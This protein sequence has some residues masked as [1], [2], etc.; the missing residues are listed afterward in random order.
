MAKVLLVEDDA[1]LRELIA[2]QIEDMGH[3][4]VVASDGKE[5]LQ[6]AAAERPQI[7]LSDIG[8]PNMNGYEFRQQLTDRY[9]HMKKLPFVFVSAYADEVDIADG[10]IAGADRYITKPIDFDLLRNWLNEL[11]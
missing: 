9:P 1:D 5:G 4:V 8:M 10:L 7:I 11:T 6:R 3:D 2:D